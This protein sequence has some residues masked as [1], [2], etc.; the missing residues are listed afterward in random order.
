MPIPYEHII[1]LAEQIGKDF[2]PLKVILFGSYA[3]GTPTEDSDID[4]LIILPKSDE[5]PVKVAGK[6]RSTLPRDIS[7]D[8]LVRDPEFVDYR[9]NHSDGF[10]SQIMQEGTVLWEN[11]CAI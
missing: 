10:I 4:I 11:G 9:V 3:W 2:Q 5:H 6:I 7:I 1:K 8:V